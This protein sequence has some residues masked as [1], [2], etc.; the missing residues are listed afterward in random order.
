MR[1]DLII[2]EKSIA[3][4]YICYPNSLLSSLNYGNKDVP[5]TSKIIYS[6][7]ISTQFTSKPL[8]YCI[9]HK[10]GI[11]TFHLYTMIV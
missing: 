1:F 3:Y 8:I 2:L 5:G 7:F 11:L 10:K 6:T 4:I 9:S